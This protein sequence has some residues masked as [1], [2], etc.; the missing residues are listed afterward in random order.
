VTARKIVIIVLVLGASALGIAGCGTPLGAPGPVAPASSAPIVAPVV[1]PSAPTAVPVVTPS[2]GALTGAEAT[3]ICSQL[4]G[5]INMNPG[6]VVGAA[7]GGDY[8][9][10]DIMG[11]A[12]CLFQVD[13]GDVTPA[14]VSAGISM[15]PADSGEPAGTVWCT[16]YSG[17]IPW[18]TA[19]SCYNDALN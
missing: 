4:G 17:N 8:Q 7:Q 13:N 10:T 9:V 2:A 12:S 11:W 15:N 16:D 19:L 3:A 14:N 1:T 6:G 5:R 18:T